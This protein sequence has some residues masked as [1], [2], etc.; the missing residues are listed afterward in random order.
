MDLTVARSAQ[1]NSF[2]PILVL[3]FLFGFF[4]SVRGARDQMV[5]CG[6]DLSTFAQFACTAHSKFNP[7][8]FANF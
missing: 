5:A 4:V 3:R 1:W 7:N 8:S 2:D 6:F